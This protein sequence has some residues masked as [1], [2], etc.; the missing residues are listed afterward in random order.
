[1]RTI[2][3]FFL[4][5][6]VPSFCSLSLLRMSLAVLNIPPV[7]CCGRQ[8]GR[9]RGESDTRKRQ[10]DT[11]DSHSA[12]ESMAAGGAETPTNTPPVA[13]GTQLT[14]KRSDSSCVDW[15]KH[16]GGRWRSRNFHK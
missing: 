13:E 5:S 16:H 15:G 3:C 1:M 10:C 7:G 12:A 6:A 9:R 8:N 11:L 14:R 2:R 4:S